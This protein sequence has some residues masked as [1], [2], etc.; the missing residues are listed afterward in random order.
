MSNQKLVRAAQAILV[1]SICGLVSTCA[2]AQSDEIDV[3]EVSAMGGFLVNPGPS[4]TD[5]R[6]MVTGSSGVALSRYLMAMFDTSFTSLGKQT[7]QG[8]PHPSIVHHSY[9]FDFGVDLHIRIP[10]GRRWAPYG[11]AGT[12]LLWNFVRKYSADSNGVAAGTG[13]NQ[14]NA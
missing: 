9:L 13:Y 12:G 11:I 3:G 2:M 5:I 7:I 4:G 1:L 8:W 10:V 6:P 14:F